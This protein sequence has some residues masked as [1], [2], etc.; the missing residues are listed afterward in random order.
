[1]ANKSL[2]LVRMVLLVFIILL[3]GLTAYL[4]FQSGKFNFS[5]IVVALGCLLI[6]LIT[7]RK[8]DSGKQ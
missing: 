7:G 2:N 1:M 4:Y 8:G 6:L 5:S 3:V